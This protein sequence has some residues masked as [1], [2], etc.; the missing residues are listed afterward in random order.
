M[1]G[2][3]LAS[4][5]RDPQAD[6]NIYIGARVL[7]GK[8]MSPSRGGF[9]VVILGT[10]KRPEMQNHIL[11]PPVLVVCSLKYRLWGRGFG[12]QIIRSCAVRSRFVPAFASL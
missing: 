11:G 9:G 6:Q 8:D 1:S 4:F 5:I 10:S 3:R 2:L 12:E 7:Y